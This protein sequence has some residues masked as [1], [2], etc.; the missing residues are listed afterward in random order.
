MGKQID[1]LRTYDPILFTRKPM[2]NSFHFRFE[3]DFF[4]L[5][6]KCAAVH[7]P[8]RLTYKYDS[9]TFLLMVILILMKSHF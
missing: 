4:L 5:Q 1:E 8:S 9:Y 3:N 7:V 6:I 2:C